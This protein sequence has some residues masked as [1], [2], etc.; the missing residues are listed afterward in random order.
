LGEYSPPTTI[1]GGTQMAVPKSLLVVAAVLFAL[2]AGTFATVKLTTEHLL[3]A[4]ATATAEK[5]A[6]NLAENVSDLEQIAAGEQPSSR[7]LSFFIWA[8]KLGIVSRY[9]IYNREG[10]SQLVADDRQIALVNISRHSPEAADAGRTLQTRVAVRSGGMEGLP[11]F[12]AEAIIPVMAGGRH[13]AT[14]AAYVDQSAERARFTK[15]FFTA[16]LGLC[17]LTGL[18]F[19]VPAVA[20]YRRTREKDR[21]D[22]ELRFLSVHDRMTGLLNRGRFNVELDAALTRVAALGGCLAVHHLDLDQLKSINDTLG[23][24]VGD[25]LIKLAAERIRATV[26]PHDIVARLGGDEFAIIQ[27]GIAI[28]GDAEG[29]ASRLTAALARP[30]VV[31]AHEIVVTA[32][33]GIALAPQHGAESGRLLKSAGLALHKGK[34]DGRNCC[35]VFTNEM[36]AELRARLDLEKRI[37]DAVHTGEFELHFQPLVAMPDGR[38]SGFEALLRLKDE[39]GQPISPSVFI[40][41]AEDMG[42]IGTIGRWVLHSA[43]AA[44]SE[45]PAHL[46]VAVNLSPAQ[47]QAGS[48]CDIVVAALAN[49][50]LDPGRLELEITETLLLRDSDAVLAELGRLK[51]LGVS[52]VM[53]DFG[54][55]YSSLSYLWRFPFDKIKIDQ[56]FMRSLDASDKGVQTIVKTTVGLGHS[57]NMKVSVEGVENARQL[58]FVRQVEC[59]Q[60]QGFFFGRPLAPVDLAACLLADLNSASARPVFAGEGKLRVVK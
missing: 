3:Y 25:A 49:S 5:W 58:E 41:I 48:V 29:L 34:A 46:T 11:D 47:F 20:W 32:S 31:N 33:V 19:G 35:R 56:A 27:L 37:R 38:L 53:D 24:A 44:A 40:P 18:A 7:S 14:V 57:L 28:A 26:G 1:P 55:G 21:A 30:F 59:D 10:Y 23:H 6:R 22:A 42:L 51:D 2:V 39:T 12:F 52:I 16:A 8:Q 15:S 36:D 4:D 45:W 9:V 60:V 54:T 13:V 50:G 17:V 43:C